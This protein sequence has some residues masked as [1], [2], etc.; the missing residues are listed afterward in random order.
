M[1]IKSLLINA[2]VKTD[3]FPSIAMTVIQ[4]PISDTLRGTG[5][6]KY[7]KNFFASN[8]SSKMLLIKA[9]KGASGNEMTNNVQNLKYL[10]F[11]CDSIGLEFTGTYPN[12]NTISKYS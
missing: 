11:K 2:V 4:I 1:M 9:N 3:I 8:L 10:E 12:C 7:T 5:L 6:L